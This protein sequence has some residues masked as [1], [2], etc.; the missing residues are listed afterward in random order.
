MV[1]VK[2]R[3]SEH[4]QLRRNANLTFSGH[5]GDIQNQSSDLYL[6]NGR[7]FLLCN[8]IGNAAGKFSLVEIASGIT[9]FDCDL[10]CFIATP[11]RDREQQLQQ[12]LLQS[13]SQTADHAEIEQR[14]PIIWGDEN[15]ARVWIGVEESLDQNLIQIGPKQ[16]F[17]QLC[18][19][20]F[21]PGQR[22]HFGNLFTGHIFHRQ[23]P[24]RAVVRNWGRN[25][26]AMKCFQMLPK[27]GEVLS[28]L[29][30]IQLAHQAF[31]QFFQ[32]APEFVPLSEFRSFIEEFCYLLERLEIFDHLFTNVWP[33][34][35]Y[36]HRSFVA[37]SG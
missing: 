29:P 14:N 34:H 24:R 23:Y 17:G 11:F 21:H 37:Q 2:Q 32:H 22:T 36:C 15:I 26:E 10:C 28:F 4:C 16:L 33:L 1:K 27:D 9:N 7:R 18:T 12:I 20:E 13:R 3:L 6:F 31:S 8:D 25:D 19:I 35:L 5:L 30:V